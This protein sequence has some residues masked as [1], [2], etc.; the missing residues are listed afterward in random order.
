MNPQISKTREG[1]RVISRQSQYLEFDNSGMDPDVKGIRPIGGPS[2]DSLIDGVDFPNV[3]DAI[4]EVYA[5]DYPINTIIQNDDGLNPAGT[6]QT[7]TLTFSGAVSFVDPNVTKAMIRV[8]GVPVVVNRDENAETVCTRVYGEL[9]KY[10]DKSIVFAAVER[11]AGQ[12]T[13]INVRFID[14]NK[15]EVNDILGYGI[16]VE[17]VIS[18]PA[19]HGLIGTWT[20][21]G[22]EEKTIAGGFVSDM[23]IHYFKRI[24]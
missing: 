10:K 21:I 11:P 6:Q 16:R 4:K 15:H 3:H 22:K 1:A 5:N 9:V 13:T 17:R 24:A 2:V 7:E 18:S 20:K 12:T 8:Y 19:I 14:Y 23:T